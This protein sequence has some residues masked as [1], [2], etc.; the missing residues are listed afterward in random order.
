MKEKLERAVSQALEK[1]TTFEDNRFAAGFVEGVNTLRNSIEPDPMFLTIWSK[2]TMKAARK[3]I[4]LM[5]G[6]GFEA[7]RDEKRR[8]LPRVLVFQVRGE[9]LD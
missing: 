5:K 2:T 4:E 1:A 6:Q 7:V 3:F 9:N 8:R